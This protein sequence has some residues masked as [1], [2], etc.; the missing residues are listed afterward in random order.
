MKPLFKIRF[1]HIG[2]SKIRMTQVYLSFTME[3]GNEATGRNPMYLGVMT[4]V[5]SFSLCTLVVPSASLLPTPLNSLPRRL[6]KNS[7]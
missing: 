6:E 2:H 7:L 5:S 1:H 4:L 3:N